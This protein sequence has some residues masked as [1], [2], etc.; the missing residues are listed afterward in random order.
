MR[1]SKKSMQRSNKGMWKKGVG[2]K[3]E[4][5]EKEGMGSSKGRMWRSMG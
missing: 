3:E 1:R 5:M 2:E 4:D